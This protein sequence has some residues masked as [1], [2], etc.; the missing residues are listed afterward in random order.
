MGRELCDHYDAFGSLRCSCLQTCSSGA[1]GAGRRLNSATTKCVIQTSITAQ[2]PSDTSPKGSFSAPGC[3]ILCWCGDALTLGVMLEGW[4]NKGCCKQLRKVPLT[5]EKEAHLQQAERE[6]DICLAFIILYPKYQ[7]ITVQSDPMK[8]NTS[9][10]SL[11]PQCTAGNS[12]QPQRSSLHALT[13]ARMQKYK[14]L[15]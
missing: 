6:P 2:L 1:A 13:E 4:H 15:T 3:L 12:A 14:S 11:K 5:W 7:E 8:C 10:S 9:S